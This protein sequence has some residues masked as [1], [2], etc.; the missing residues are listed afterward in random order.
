ME[1]QVI[2]TTFYIICIFK[3]KEKIQNIHVENLETKFK[4][5]NL[6]YANQPTTSRKKIF[7]EDA[8]T[9]LGRIYYFPFN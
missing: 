4:E 7:I 2:S 8:G 6:Q 1:T 3:E 9:V 5:A